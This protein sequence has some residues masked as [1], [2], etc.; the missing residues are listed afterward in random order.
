MKTHEILVAADLFGS[1][2]FRTPVMA[3]RISQFRPFVFVVALCLLASLSVSAAG[4]A[5]YRWVDDQ[6]NVHYAEIVPQRYQDVAKRVDAPADEPSA[7]QRREA[8][9]RAEQNKAK[10]AELATQRATERAT[11]RAADEAAER[12]KVPTG[13]PPAAAASQPAG[14]LPAQTPNAQ[15]DCKTWQRLYQESMACFGPFRTVGGGTKAEAFAHCNVVAEPPA[16]RCK[17]QIP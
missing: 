8:L 3:T 11:E 13:A 4:A 14:K 9:A 2:S 5:V 6:G 16:G 1:P 7:E 15:T 17:L 12:Q 10:A